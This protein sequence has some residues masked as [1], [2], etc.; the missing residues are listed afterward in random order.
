VG[1]VELIVADPHFDSGEPLAIFLA[2]I[3]RA[4]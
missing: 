4:E 1:V 3:D 2:A